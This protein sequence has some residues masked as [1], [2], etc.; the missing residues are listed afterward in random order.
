MSR[1]DLRQK[2]VN[3]VPKLP[4]ISPFMRASYQEDPKGLDIAMFGVPFGLGSSNRTGARHGPSQM[5]EMSRL[6]RQVHYPSMAEPFKDYRIADIGDAPVNSL[7]IPESL[8]HIKRFDD[9][10]I[11]AGAL[12]LAA[13]ARPN[14]DLIAF[15]DWL[16]D[17]LIE[18]R[19]EENRRSNEPQ[20]TYLFST[21]CPDNL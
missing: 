5:R 13:E 9:R 3:S 2:D 12:P 20:V 14:G 1:P 8:E 16:V 11:D 19:I 7:S 17:S 6:I 4:N 18:Y 10:I 15:R 21:S